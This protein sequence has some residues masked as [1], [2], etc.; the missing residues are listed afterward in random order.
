MA[1]PTTPAVGDSSTTSTSTTTT[2]LA[3][4][5]AIEPLMGNYTVTVVDELAH[6]PYAF[7]QGLEWHDGW[8]YEST[9][10]YEQSDL[11]RIDPTTGEVDALVP[12][13]DHLFGEGLTIVGGEI[14]QLS[15]REGELLRSGIDDLAPI[16]T[17]RYEGD[18]WGLCHDGDHL[19]MSSGTNLLTK[20]DPVTFEVVST[21]AVTTNGRPLEMLNELECV[22][23]QILANV[24]GLDQIVVIDAMSGIV[25]AVVDAS[26][27]RPDGL[28]ADNADY[29]LNGI[30]FQPDTG[31][32]YL[33]GKY[34][35]VMYEVEIVAS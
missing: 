2:T 13:A 17:Q 33:T 12:L 21:L 8:L 35:P 16:T 19:I 3:A 28:S 5:A 18:G 30:A 31:R 20:R 11:R 32:W 15:W 10:Q 4:P 9:G 29:V 22:G 25:V 24:Y 14:L 7:T 1:S 26:A 34:W 23:D 6:D 27:L